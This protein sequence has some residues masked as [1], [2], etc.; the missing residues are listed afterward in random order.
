MIAARPAEG[1]GMAVDAQTMRPR[2][3]SDAV[4]MASHPLN[5]PD[6]ANQLVEAAGAHPHPDSSLGFPSYEPTGG[7]AYRPF[8]GRPVIP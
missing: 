6:V 7:S 3:R 2:G 5:D 4:L 8:G 1:E